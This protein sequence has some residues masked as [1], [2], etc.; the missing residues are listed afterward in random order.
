MNET[1]QKIVDANFKRNLAIFVGSGISI[2]ANKPGQE[3]KRWSG[4]IDKMKGE[5][6]GVKEDDYL[7]LAQLYYLH[8]KN[9]YAKKV[10][11]FIPK[12]KESSVVHRQI[13]ELNPQ[14]I[15]TTN[16]DDLLTVAAK[17]CSSIY[18]TICSDKELSKSIL[19]NKIIKMHGDFRHKNFVLKEEDYIKYQ[20]NFPLIENFVKSILST[21]TILF[22]GYSY[23]DINLKY[24]MTWLQSNSPSA[25]EMFLTVNEKNDFQERYLKNYGIKTLLLDKTDGAPNELEEK[26]K[27]VYHFLRQLKNKGLDNFLEKDG[28]SIQFVLNKLLPLDELNA[29]L[30][31][32]ITRTLS[33]CGFIYTSNLKPALQFY[34]KLGSYDCNESIRKIYADFIEKLKLHRDKKLPKESSLLLEKIFSI[35]KK[36]NIGA[37]I[38]SSDWPP[39]KLDSIDIELNDYPIASLGKYLSFDFS[40]KDAPAILK[41]FACNKREATFSLTQKRVHSSFVKRKYIQYFIAAFNYNAILFRLKNSPL[42]DAESNV[43]MNFELLDLDSKYASFPPEAKQSTHL[44]YEI[45]NFSG[46]YRYITDVA[47]LKEKIAK[48]KACIESGGFVGDNECDRYSTEHL[49]LMTFVLMND[50]M[51]EH[52]SSYRKLNYDFLQI[53]LDR[54]VGTQG[55]LNVFE[56]FACMKYL[57]RDE[58]RKLFEAFLPTCKNG[59]YVKAEKNFYIAEQLK[60]WLV[61]HVLKNLFRQYRSTQNIHATTSTYISNVLFLLSLLELPEEKLNN[62]I[63]QCSRAI[64]KISLHSYIYQAMNYFI[65]MQYTL[66]RTPFQSEKLWDIQDTLIIKIMQRRASRLEQN[67]IINGS[68]ENI[69]RYCSESKSLYQNEILMKRFLRFLQNQVMNVQIEYSKIFLVQIY[70]CSS[71]AIQRN[72]KKYFFT[73]VN[74]NDAHG[75]FF[76]LSLRLILIK[77]FSVKDFDIDSLNRFIKNYM[78][79]VTYSSAIEEIAIL[80]HDIRKKYKSSIFDETVELL[81]AYN[82]PSN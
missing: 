30:L 54:Q 57:S 16:W 62:V 7:K 27:K 11:D 73:L 12:V 60:E 21:H 35:L 48:Q 44:I 75:T 2:A 55:Q 52:E 29:I 78:S 47:E 80:V 26:S 77:V 23:N 1:I 31:L 33:N 51:I 65:G 49:N 37:I 42:S 59:Q 68:L 9:Q 10:K 41:L 43:S 36:A 4:L 66:H 28:D 17:E 74:C 32:Q 72:L 20:S 8:D 18:D 25:P 45:V 22:I 38:L 46:I 53:T 56:I 14:I 76:V 82:V 70:Q 81:K 40:G 67:V 6:P 64:R 69:Y 71:K 39:Q 34:Q 63:E 15:I 5:M 19:A 79:Q 61:L 3:F 58:L 13:I 24:I 50:L